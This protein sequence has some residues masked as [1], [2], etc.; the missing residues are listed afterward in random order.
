MT[1][2]GSRWSRGRLRHA[3]MDFGGERD[4]MEEGERKERQTREQ[5]A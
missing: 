2:N 3:E 1:L 5:E 4:E